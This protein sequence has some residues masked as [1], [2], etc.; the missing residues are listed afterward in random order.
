VL[1]WC[2]LSAFNKTSFSSC[3]L[4][5]HLVFSVLKFIEE[6]V[7][8]SGVVFS[9]SPPKSLSGFKS[10]KIF[11]EMLEKNLIFAPRVREINIIEKLI[12]HFEKTDH[13]ESVPET[14]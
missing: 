1:F 10:L 3:D 11:A 5:I 6:E 12:K 7:R 9:R 14:E 2:C 8:A 13:R 4:R